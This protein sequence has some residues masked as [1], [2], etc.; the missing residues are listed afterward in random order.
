MKKNFYAILLIASGLIW[1]FV[2]FTEF[3]IWG[4]TAQVWPIFIIVP[5]FAIMLFANSIEDGSWLS[6]AGA[7]VLATGLLL[8]Y[9]FAFDHFASWAY[10][11]ALVTPGAIGVGLRIHAKRFGD[12][13]QVPLANKLMSLGAV[14]FLTGAVFFEIVINISGR[15]TLDSG[16]Y[17]YLFPAIFVGAGLIVLFVK[18]K[19]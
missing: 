6:A 19:K 17:A 5:G 9:Q 3:N 2:Q 14:M 10:A 11:W 1:A 15:S 7:V 12:Q 8:A 13:S 16:I 4:I 18:P